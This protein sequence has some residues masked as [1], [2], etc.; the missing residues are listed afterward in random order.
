MQ[1]FKNEDDYKKKMSD[2]E[3]IEERS[4]IIG[5]IILN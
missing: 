2:I 3:Y 4:L 1:I 5:N